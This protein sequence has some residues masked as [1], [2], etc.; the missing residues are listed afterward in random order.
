[1]KKMIFPNPNTYPINPGGM[2]LSRNLVITHDYE[3]DSYL[4]QMAHFSSVKKSFSFLKSEFYK[5]LS[6]GSDNSFFSAGNCDDQNE[7]LEKEYFLLAQF[8]GSIFLSSDFII[9]A[10]GSSNEICLKHIEFDDIPLKTEIERLNPER[11]RDVKAL[12]LRAK[13]EESYGPFNPDEFIKVIELSSFIK[14]TEMGLFITP[15][16]LTYLFKHYPSPECVVTKWK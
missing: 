8:N 5:Y 12:I 11:F 13:K 3:L 9:A 14:K 10:I 6:D 15:R 7:V 4:T 1:M 16:L 2:V